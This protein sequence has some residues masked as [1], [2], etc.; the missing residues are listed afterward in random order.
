M[1]TR[2]FSTENAKFIK[3]TPGGEQYTCNM[4]TASTCE[5]AILLIDAR[6]GVLDQTVV[7]FISHAA[8]I[9]HRW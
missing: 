6:K 5:L 7:S 9:K 8:G 4:A 1:R 3:P 2:H